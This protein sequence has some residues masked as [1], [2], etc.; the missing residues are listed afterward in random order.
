MKERD[1]K[2]LKKQVVELLK[3]EPEVKRIVIFGSFLA[4]ANPHD[5]D[6]AV[7][8]NSDRAYLPLAL[9]YRKKMR[10]LSRKIALDIVPIRENAEQ[11]QFLLEVN[12]GEKIYE[13]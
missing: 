12:S 1:K 9:K 11:S 6:I 8:Q 3:D 10:P 7:F 5:I 13:R 2:Y 4:S